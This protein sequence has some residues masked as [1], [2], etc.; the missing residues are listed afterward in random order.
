MENEI[1]TCGDGSMTV[2]SAL[3]GETYHSESGSVNESA[4]VY[5]ES[6]LE[7]YFRREFSSGK[8]DF[9]IKI[10]EA[11]LGTGIDVLLTAAWAENAV[12]EQP[13]IQMAITY[14]AIE[15]Y[16]LGKEEWERLDFS[17]SVK[18]LYPG[19]LSAED[20]FRKIH[21]C[22]WETPQ[23]ITPLLTLTKRKA[24]LSDAG[25]YLAPQMQETDIV[26]YDAF[27]PG[28]QPELW[29][30][31]IF[32]GIFS[33]MKP[34]GILTTYSAKG[35]VKGNLRAA[36]FEVKRKKGFAGKRHMTFAAKPV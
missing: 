4:H 8:R 14:T 3:F 36:G 27:S 2:R 26:F 19:F 18:N 12:K 28:T 9:R 35:T 31:E 13:D 16:P 15:L 21:A 17:T 34:G 6:A 10:A 5:I 7:E 11:G 32:S 24:D 23:E 30:A 29:S 25:I 22:E 20:T 1:I 33:M